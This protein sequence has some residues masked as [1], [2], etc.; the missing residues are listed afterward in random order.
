M[1]TN[2]AKSGKAVCYFFRLFSGRR[3]CF[4]LFL[5][6]LPLLLNAQIVSTDAQEGN[7][8]SLPPLADT[9]LIMQYLFKANS[10][11]DENPDSALMI[12]SEVL[13]KSKQAG[14]PRGIINALNYSSKIYADKG[15]YDRGLFLL[16]EAAWYGNHSEESRRELF[17][18]YNNIGI[19]YNYRSE[20]YQA[21]QYYY[22][23][24]RLAEKYDSTKVAHIYNNLAGVLFH[25]GLERR[26]LYYLEK[27]RQQAIRTRQLS[28]LTK[29]LLNIGNVY[30]KRS[31]WDQAAYYYNSALDTARAYKIKE[32]EY[33]ALIGL[34]DLNYMQERPNEILTLLSEAESLSVTPSAYRKNISR[35]L[36]GVAWYQLGD[37]QKAEQY[38]SD[39]LAAA[40]AGQ[41]P[42]QIIKSSEWLAR[43]Y[44]ATGRYALA[45]RQLDSCMAVKDSVQEYTNAQSISQL[46]V[47]YQSA[48]KDKELAEHKLRI[49]QQERNIERK[50]R[51]ITIGAGGGLMIILVAFGVYR[52]YRNK[53]RV[54]AKHIEIL[55]QKQ[56]ILNQKQEISQLRAMMQGEEKERARIARELHDGIGGML[57]AVKMN[58]NALKKQNPILAEVKGLDNVMRILQDTSAEVRKTAHNLMPDILVKHKLPEAIRIYCENINMADELFV[59]LQ[60]HGDLETLDKAVDLLV[61]RT[62]QELLQNVIKH[63]RATR[64]VVQIIRNGD[65]LSL[66]VEDDGKGFDPQTQEAGY[67]LQNLK[68]RIQA[69]HGNISIESAEAIGTT[70]FIKLNLQQLKSTFAA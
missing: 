62:T 14:F 30:V 15:L 20:Y 25:L 52:N 21:A 4:V 27:A 43:V 26:P 5:M 58:L 13:Q 23:A 66:I 54:Q 45:F 47:R 51:L 3:G 39:A 49:A 50:N 24:A 2:L 53:Q 31:D 42:E 9:G 12:Y 57:S 7:R 29:I 19:I 10:L 22:M 56:E 6:L 64:A 65:E 38:L 59:S 11:A 17:H 32:S 67:G 16:N 36:S 61:Y 60:L 35:M 37:Y 8:V 34:A 48:Q 46:E 40:R 41:S 18:T 70:I 63:A 28:T 1:A 68:F 44:A 69:L 55:Q 33:E